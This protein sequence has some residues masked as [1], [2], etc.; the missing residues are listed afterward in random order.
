MRLLS[1]SR[2]FIRLRCFISTEQFD[3]QH[4][5]NPDLRL[6]SLVW[7][8]GADVFAGLELALNVNVITALQHSGDFDYGTKSHATVPFGFGFPFAGLLIFPGVLRCDGEDRH[9]AVVGECL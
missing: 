9:L 8:L 1:S 7:T 2:F 6:A 5:R 3:S 4:R